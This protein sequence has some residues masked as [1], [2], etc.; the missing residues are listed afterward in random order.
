MF[1]RG[2]FDLSRFDIAGEGVNIRFDVAFAES[3]GG[4]FGLGTDYRIEGLTMT[5]ALR[6]TSSA[7]AVVPYALQAGESL[8]FGAQGIL[9]APIEAAFGESMLMGAKLDA[10]YSFAAQL[11]DALGA[12]TWLGADV[13]FFVDASDSLQIRAL[14]GA[15]IDYSAFLTEILSVLS[16]A[17]SLEEAT[18]SVNVSIPPGSQ[19]RIDSENFTV[20]LDGKN[21]LH[22]QEGDWIELERELWGILINT[23]SGGALSGEL[24]YTERYL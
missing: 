21:I 12:R 14:L 4:F 23:G 18:L 6:Q 19:L 24:I 11:A 1:G 15:D 20:T 17:A 16:D 2:R 22:L 3:L 10:D 9:A 7:A 8:S 13:S 5:A